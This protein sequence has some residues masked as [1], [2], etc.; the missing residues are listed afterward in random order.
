MGFESKLT[1]KGQ[2]TIPIE[3][4]EVLQLKPGDRIQYVV[5][6]D[7]RVEMIPR[8]RSVME[9]AGI[10]YDPE[11]KP[12]SLEEMDEAIGE[13]IVQRNELSLDRD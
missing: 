12:V 7:G 13:A 2:T 6:P 8:N 5:M 9:L 10:L 1:S 11:R 4:R 3:I